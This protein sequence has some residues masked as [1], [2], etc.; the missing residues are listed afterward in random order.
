MITPGLVDE[1]NAQQLRIAGCT[2]QSPPPPRRTPTGKTLIVP[3]SSNRGLCSEISLISLRVTSID[4]GTSKSFATIPEDDENAHSPSDNDHLISIDRV[5]ISLGLKFLG[6]FV[7][8]SHCEPSSTRALPTSALIAK[9]ARN[10]YIVKKGM[11]AAFR[12]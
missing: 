7:A 2:P 8:Q 10:Y 5:R 11:S 12:A 6:D 1:A 3:L 9:Y 4:T